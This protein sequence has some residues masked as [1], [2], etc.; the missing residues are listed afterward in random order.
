[1]LASERPGEIDRYRETE[2]EHQTYQIRTV[3]V[4]AC[5]LERERKRHDERQR[6]RDRD[7]ETRA[8]VC[9]LDSF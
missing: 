9:L 4:L 3:C 6:D 5:L 1:V 2:C 7:R 8:T